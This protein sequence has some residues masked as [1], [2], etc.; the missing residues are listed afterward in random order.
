MTRGAGGSSR[1]RSLFL[2]GRK[3]QEIRKLAG[4]ARDLLRA[5]NP[6]TYRAAE[7]PAKKSAVLEPL[8]AGPVYPT[9][10]ITIIA[11]LL[12]YPTMSTLLAGKVLA[13]L[14]LTQAAARHG[15]LGVEAALAEVEA[16]AVE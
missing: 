11:G 12:V 6:P 13:G 14:V 4:V 5:R 9:M 15:F 8:G 16:S 2:S 1:P 10:M 3:A 7:G